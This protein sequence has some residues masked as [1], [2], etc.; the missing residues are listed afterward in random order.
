VAQ[1]VIVRMEREIIAEVDHRVEMR[2]GTRS[3]FVRDAVSKALRPTRLR[4]VILPYLA[5]ATLAAMFGL[6]MFAMVAIVVRL[7]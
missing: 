1:N 3:D 2:G 5:L 6:C 4:S 7:F